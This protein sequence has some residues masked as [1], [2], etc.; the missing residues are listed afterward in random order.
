M[1]LEE[2][3]LFDNK[4]D[5]DEFAHFLKARKCPARIT[6]QSI[7]RDECFLEGRLGGFFQLLEKLE[8]MQPGEDD[9]GDMDEDES[10]YDEDDSLYT[11]LA[12]D[13]EDDQMIPVRIMLKVM[14]LDLERAW[15]YYSDIIGENQPGD[16]VVKSEDLNE[17]LLDM[18]SSIEADDEGL[19]RPFFI[20][21]IRELHY[22]QC[23]E[24]NGLI[25]DSPEG[26]VLKKRIDPA[27]I[28]I[29]R[30]PTTR[31]EEDEEIVRPFGLVNHTST[32][33]DTRYSLMIDPKLH[34][35]FTPDE[36]SEALEELSVNDE[37]WD[38][39]LVHMS[40]TQQLLH[41]MLGVIGN[42]KMIPVDELYRIF[43]NY[44][45]DTSGNGGRTGIHVSSEYINDLIED[46][47]KLRV[48]QG[49]ND[50]IRLAT[51]KWVIPGQ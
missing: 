44:R 16:L 46:L 50:R 37:S 9:D 35:L 8:S 27:D 31:Y 33:F 43:D 41:I 15:V 48:I 7:V 29:T 19:P 39:L 17:E 18:L 5:A 11:G 49:N 30:L 47:R 14:R 32:N 10:S 2:L 20:D 34:F 6:I 23:L 1:V 25:E 22:R 12:D 3:L 21:Y 51:Q 4:E 36:I 45:V 26:I 28:V 38:A 13:E 40:R 42:E 24:K